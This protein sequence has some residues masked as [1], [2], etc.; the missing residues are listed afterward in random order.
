MLKYVIIIALATNLFNA[1]C[2]TICNCTANVANCT[3]KNLRFFPVGKYSKTIT[4]LDVSYNNLETIEKLDLRNRY[5]IHLTHLNLS[6]N[7]IIKIDGNSFI[8]QRNLQ[9][10]D[11]SGNNIITL[12]PDVLKYLPQLKCLNLSN[13]KKLKLTDGYPFLISDTL[14]VLYL[15]HCDLVHIPF[16][17]IMKLKNLKVLYLSNNK[18][19]NIHDY[20]GITLNSLIDLDLSGNSL[21]SL[22]KEIISSHDDL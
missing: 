18:I 2:P 7:A 19:R 17:A 10:V 5:I 14:E 9:E 21:Q 3:Y 12:P 20:S 13:N 15:E 4:V 1:E 22:R 11:L 16:K 6:N 8:G